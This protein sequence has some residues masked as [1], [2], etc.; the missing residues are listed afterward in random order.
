MPPLPDDAAEADDGEED[1][2]EDEEEEKEEEDDDDEEEEEDDDKEEEEEDEEEEEEEENDEAEEL[3]PLLPLKL[4][5]G[6]NPRTSSSLVHSAAARR[7]KDMP[8]SICGFWPRSPGSHP[9]RFC[10]FT[11][12]LKALFASVCSRTVSV[13]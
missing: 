7:R 3:W 6:L 10:C 13:K 9:W 4:S 8:S 5:E 12:S 11:A 2:E 1:E